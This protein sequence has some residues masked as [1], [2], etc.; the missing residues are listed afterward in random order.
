M[1]GKVSPTLRALLEIRDELREHRRLTDERF[2]ELTGRVARLETGVTAHATRVSTELVEVT[3]VMKDVR[4]L[5]RERLDLR[6]RVE[7]HEQRIAA[8]EGLGRR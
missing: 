1:P 8:L 4:E 6:D 7:D 2:A 3:A 5:L